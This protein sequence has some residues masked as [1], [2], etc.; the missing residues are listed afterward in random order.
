MGIFKKKIQKTD[1]PN[2]ITTPAES[3]AKY[4][5]LVLN[6]LNEKLGGTLYDNCVIMPKGYTIDVQIGRIGESN[7]VQLVQVVFIVKNDD[8]DEPLIEPVDAQG[9][10]MEDAAKMSVEIFYGSLWH[11]IN[12]SMTKK[13]PQHIS[14]NYLQQHYDFDMY[15][16]SVVRIGVD[17]SKKPTMLINYIKAEI[18]KFLGSKKY[19]WVRMYLAKMHDKKI[20][21][22]RVNGSVCP[23]LAEFFKPYVDSWEDSDKFICEKQ[24]AIFVQREDDKC[25]FDKAKVVECA[26]K[27]LERMTEIKSPEDYKAMSE[28][29]VEWTGDRNLASEIRIFIPEIMAKLTLGYREGD[30][31]FLMEGEGEEMSRI[32]FKKTQ[33]RS[34]FYIQQVI[35]EFLSQRPGEDKPEER[36]EFDDKVRN[37]FGNSIAYREVAKAIKDGHKPQELYVPGT[38]YKIG[39]GDYKV[40]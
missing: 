29:L 22:V 16:Q 5:D 30:S 23:T 36:K 10:Q 2:P 13:N 11:P 7:G 4:K 31:L 24:Y 3:A 39:S 34:Y 19:Y 17:E 35:Q 27:A 20:I 37:I 28:D 12:Q 1:N 25:P 9:V 26:K 18:V 14:V 40:W 32:E 21:E 8:F 15:C 6:A 33:L 38:A